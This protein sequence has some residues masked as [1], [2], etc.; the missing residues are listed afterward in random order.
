MDNAICVRHTSELAL[1]LR[2]AD[3]AA[4]RRARLVCV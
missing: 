3:L 4:A 1:F 2:V